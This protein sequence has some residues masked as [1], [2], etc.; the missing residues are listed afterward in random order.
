MIDWYDRAYA[1]PT[2]AAADGAATDTVLDDGSAP[3]VASP[4]YR[5]GGA[6]GRAPPGRLVAAAVAERARGPRAR[7]VDRR[8]SIT[9]VDHDE[10][11]PPQPVLAEHATWCSTTPRR[12]AATWAPTCGARPTCATTCCP[13]FQLSGWSMDWYGGLPDVPLLHGG[14]G[15]G[16][17]RPRRRPA[18]TAWRSSSSAILGLV[19]LPFCCW[20]FGRL[21]RFRYPMPEL[22]AFAGLCFLLDESFSDLR[23]QPEVDDGGRVLVLDRAVARRCSASACSPAGCGP[24]ST[25]SG[26]RSCSPLAC[27]SPRHRADLRR[28]SARCMLCARVDRPH[29]VHLRHH[30]R[31]H[32]AAAVGVVG[33]PVP[34]QPRVHDRHEVRRAARR[35]RTTRSGTC[36]S[37]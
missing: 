16:D 34:A 20:A 2:G 37:R 29:A 21:A 26:R 7:H 13:H 10:R 17:R 9:T 6:A 33:R 14:A 5:R 30:G 25:A 22:F 15:A 24:A 31:R 18:R 3:P 27:V 11:R 28:R 8:W 35:A 4:W 19:T 32:G 23:R 12:P 1:E 36:S